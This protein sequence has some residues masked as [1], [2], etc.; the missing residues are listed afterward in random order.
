ML[1]CRTAP[2]SGRQWIDRAANRPPP[3]LVAAPWDSP[4]P[5]GRRGLAPA[6]LYLRR[7]LLWDGSAGTDRIEVDG[8]AVGARPLPAIRDANGVGEAEQPDGRRLVVHRR[9]QLAQQYV[10]LQVVELRDLRFEQPIDLGVGPTAQRAPALVE[11]LEQ[12]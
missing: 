8:A 10:A 1:G 2:H 7:L 3:N 4:T 9:L 6:L 12:V 5:A 11:E